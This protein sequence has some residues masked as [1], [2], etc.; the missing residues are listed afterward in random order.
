[1]IRAVVFDCF[2]VLATDIWLQFC[3]RLPEGADVLRARDLSKA[4]NRGMI[5]EQEYIDGVHEATGSEPPDINQLNASQLAK[6]ELLLE[7]IQTLR[8]DYK[9]GLLSNISS[10]WVTRVLLSAEDQRLFD[11]MVFS[12]EVGMIKPNPSIYQLVCERL[13]VQPEETVMVDDIPSY[14]Q[15]G[16]DLGMKGLLYTDFARFKTGLAELLNSN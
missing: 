1:M 13:G 5:T 14:V 4:Y 9:I 2:G 8:P 12:Y 10:D 6:N 3:D 15:A 16:V 7:H 11:T